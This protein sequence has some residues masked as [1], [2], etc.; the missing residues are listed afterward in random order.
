[1]IAHKA[2]NLLQEKYAIMCIMGFKPILTKNIY[3][4]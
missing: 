1:M 2:Y 3:I 4:V